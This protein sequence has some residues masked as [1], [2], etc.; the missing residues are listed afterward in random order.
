MHEEEENILNPEQLRTF[1]HELPQV[2]VDHDEEGYWRM[3]IPDPHVPLPRFTDARP[4]NVH[5]VD[6]LCGSVTGELG[7]YCSDNGYSIDPDF[8]LDCGIVYLAGQA[9]RDRLH[10]ALLAAIEEDDD[11]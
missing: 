7:A 10:D 2:V 3:H 4:D 5:A 11:E 8:C 1:L 9:I 6:C